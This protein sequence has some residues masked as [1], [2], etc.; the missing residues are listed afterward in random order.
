MSLGRKGAIAT[1]LAVALL[2]GGAGCGVDLGDRDV[3]EGEPLELG[4]IAFNVQLTR[5]LNPTDREDA[6][7][8]QGQQVPPPPGK[9]YLAVFM[10]VNNESADDLPLPGPTDM[11]V[12][13]TTGAKY[14]PIASNSLFALDL[15]GTILAHTDLPEEDTAAK[16]GPTG[17]SIV[18]FLVDEGVSENRPLE[19]EVTSGG[20]KGRIELDI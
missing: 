15:G 8:L 6:E 5:F 20:E 16:A 17:G 14:T 2:A 4:D 18:F 19:L 10:Q 13:D 9:A 11:T 1:A 3:V 12:V 7:Y